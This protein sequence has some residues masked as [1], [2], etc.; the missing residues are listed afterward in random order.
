MPDAREERRGPDRRRQPRG[1]RRKGDV[2]GFA[3]LV[4][5]VAEDQQSREIAETILAK[6][7]FAVAPFDSVEKAISVM[8]ALRPQVVVAAP[9]CVE[10]LRAHAGTTV[11][12]VP[13][14]SEVAGTDALVEAIRREL[15]E[16]AGG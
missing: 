16:T 13:A 2:G 7:R 15:R 11:A 10:Q 4:F 3:P 6:L 14:T 12:I 1:G 8:N 9:S 5:V